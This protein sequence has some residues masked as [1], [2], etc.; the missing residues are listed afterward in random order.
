MEINV[1]NLIPAFLILKSIDNFAPFF[2][3][4]KTIEN[5]IN[6]K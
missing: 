5:G 1:F 2:N 3:Q 6:P 4:L